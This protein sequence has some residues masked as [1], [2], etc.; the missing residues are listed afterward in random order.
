MSNWINMLISLSDM[1]PTRRYDP[2]ALDKLA[3][4]R[5]EQ[6]EATD[7]IDRILEGVDRVYYAA[8]A[9]T[10][11]MMT[12]A[13]AEQELNQAAAAAEVVPQVIIAAAQIK[14]SLRAAPGNPKR[15]AVEYAAV[16]AYVEGEAHDA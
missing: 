9:V 5:Q 3:R 16:K 4:E 15:P 1:L 10:N 7:Q 2:K 14:Y 12:E 13:E 6:A 8:K 11:S